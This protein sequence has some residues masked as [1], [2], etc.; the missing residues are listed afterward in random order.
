LA[1]DPANGR[2]LWRDSFKGNIFDPITG[3]PGVAFV[4]T[5]ARRW[6]A[7][8]PVT[9]KL[10]WSMATPGGVAGGAAIS[11]NYVVWGYGFLLFKAK[12]DGGIAALTVR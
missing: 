11:G 1:L 8:D 2:V 3:V 10:L 6:Y 12:G 4:G 5:D 9:G 7:L